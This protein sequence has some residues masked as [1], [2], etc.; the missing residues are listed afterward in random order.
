[1]LS[2]YSVIT[3]FDRPET[4]RQIEANADIDL[5]IFTLD[6]FKTDSYQLL[7]MICRK[8]RENTRIIVLS[9]SNTAE[10][11]IKCLDLGVHDY[12]RAPI[13]MQVLKTRVKNQLEIFQ[14]QELSEHKIKNAELKLDEIFKQAPIGISISY[15]SEPNRDFTKN[16][17]EVNAR[18]EQIC[19]RTKNELSSV[20]WASITHPDDL[21]EDLRLFKKL[22]SGEINSYSMDKRFIKPDGSIVWVHM[23][24]ATLHIKNENR[25]NHICLVQEITQRKALELALEEKTR[26]LNIFMDSSQ[27]LIYLKDDKFR[28]IIANQKLADF[29]GMDV[30]QLIGK[31]DYDVMD[32]EYADNCRKTDEEA[33]INTKASPSIERVGG[34]VF[35][36]RKF[37]VPVSEGKMGVGAYIRDITNEYNQKE[38]VDKIS[39]TNRII[40]QCMLKS[41]TDIQEQL[42]YALHEALKLTGS[43]Y[44]YIY[45]YNEDTK[46]FTLNSWTN[47]VMA[48]C[49][50]MEKQTKYHLVKTGLWGE[51]VR[52]RKP[53]IV[54][55]FDAPDPYK[56]GYP[57]GHVN[58]QRFMSI[59]IFENEKIVAVIGFANKKS[60]YSD[61]DIQAMT[62]LMSGVW[63]T[64][65][66]KEK[67]KETEIL[68]A[69]TQ[70]MVND[71][72][73][74]MLLVE[75]FSGRIIEA[76]SAAISFYGYSKEELLNM[77]IQDINML[78]KDEVRELRLKALNKQQK[79]LTFPSRLKNGEIRM[80]DVYSSPIEYCGNKVMFSIVFDVTKREEVT[81]L[82]E[83]M[84][85]HDYL[86][87]LY[88]RRYFEEEFSK[89]HNGD[90]D[91][92]PIVIL[93]GDVNGL[94]IFNDA[95]GHLEGDRA[96]IDIA[97]SIKECIS[98]D[99]IL[100]RIGGDEFAVIVSKTNE[101]EIKKYIDRLEQEVNYRDENK[102]KNSL[103][104]SFGYGI[105]RKKEDA[106]DDLTKE[107]EAFM[108][109]R[110]YYNSKS[111][112]SNV[113]NVIMETL[114]VK[115]ERE[116]EH[117]QRVGL[118]CEA[119]ATKMQLDKQEIKRMQVTGLL[120]DIGKIG[121]DE[122]IL[123]KIG[124]LD[125]NEWEAM[126]L[127]SVKGARILENTIEFKDIAENV[128]SH[129]E[130]YDGSG[131]PKGLKGKEIPV[132]ARIIAIADAYDA[133]TNDR[134]Y[135]NKMSYEEAI[136]ELKQ[137]S[138]IQFDPEIVSLFISEVIPD[139]VSSLRS[140]GDKFPFI[141][142]KR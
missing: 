115:S 142:L 139:I 29:F 15:N 131:Y 53:I 76:N 14:K 20:G 8:K 39:E 50:I 132:M 45:F 75:P 71:H 30:D 73:A 21:D 40:M 28:H 129:H 36:T 136:I 64:T 107:A 87:G 100:A 4:I 98:S 102:G 42:D 120:H 113:V 11:E 37:P 89:L 137:Y 114:F 93:M 104:I 46:E 52:Q 125:K 135:R 123:N 109:N 24:V 44:G 32:I 33:I 84:A 41:F 122:S 133:M 57:E 18:F 26:R 48:D 83:Y 97:D 78:S 86:T 124:K 66:K 81:K 118:I 51:V 7:D 68:L 103:T 59:P 108:Y 116:K 128:L 70:A 61:N 77:A 5:I 55:D 140:A 121:V 106:L 67:E 92:Y 54:N 19:G 65:K 134:T 2:E 111:T 63:I 10:D 94:K 80:V 130:H 127:H 23:I 126:K 6:I 112:R 27:D 17:I 34:K 47:G 60:D 99:S 85:Y 141:N 12:I 43:Q 69:R 31:T 138:G 88:N 95:F 119:I 22:Q 110:K 56:K 117:S 13:Q 82:N 74:V 58:I 25:Y 101:E 16:F 90:A 3:T 35:E 72:E 38:I 9:Y 91:E 1:M 105:Q 62:V 49:S 96:L 79:Y